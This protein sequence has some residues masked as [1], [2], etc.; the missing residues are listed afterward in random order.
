[1]EFRQPGAISSTLSARRT[2]RCAAKC[3]SLP[4]RPSKR[5]IVGSVRSFRDWFAAKNAYPSGTSLQRLR[6]IQK[7]HRSTRMLGIRI[8]PTSWAINLAR[9][10][11]AA[12][13]LTRF[14]SSSDSYSWATLRGEDAT[15]ARHSSQLQKPY[16]SLKYQQCTIRAK[17]GPRGG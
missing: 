8:V 12:C 5:Q 7:S 11:V 4:R 10:I 6:Q 2:R 3:T 14:R 17:H 15:C 16:S 1:M 13:K 9:S